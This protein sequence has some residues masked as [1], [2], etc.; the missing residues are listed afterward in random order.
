MHLLAI[1][2]GGTKLQICTGDDT[3]HIHQRHRFPVDPSEGGVGIRRQLES[4][5]KNLLGEVSPAA[6][7]VGF[8]GPVD[9]RRGTICCS[10]QVEGWAGFEL[11]DWMRERGGRPVAVENDTNSGALGEAR[12][13][14]GRGF[15]PVF[16]FNMGSGVGGGLAVGGHIYHGAKPGEAEFG[17]LRLDRTGTTVESRCSGWA[18][19]QKIRGLIKARPECAL[20]RLVGQNPGA[21]A[22]HLSAALRQGDRDARQILDETAADLGFALS[23]AVHLFHPETIVMGG[24]LALVGE[25][26]RAAVEEALRAHVME[27]FR[28]AP[29]IRLAE[30]KEDAV[31]VGALLLAAEAARAGA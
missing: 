10:H 3:G 15:N 5:L 1:E 27:V 20:A 7:G 13:G 9:W 18:V 12:R 21:E 22:R 23:H 16:Y 14:A 17:H 2:I 4:A 30:L 29:P 19:D 25:P 31:P 28:P 24:G 11:G 6:I 26:L 8:G